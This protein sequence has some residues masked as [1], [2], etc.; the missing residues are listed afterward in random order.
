[1]TH[2]QE[3]KQVTATA[4][5][6]VQIWNLASK[7][8]KAAIIS[9]RKEQKKTMYKLLKEDVRTMFHQIENINK[10]I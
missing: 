3:E 10:D 5:E 2:T 6:G 8:F 9:M 4:F 7:D 1:M